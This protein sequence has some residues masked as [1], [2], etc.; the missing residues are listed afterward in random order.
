MDAQLKGPTVFMRALN[1]GL[2]GGEEL[3]GRHGVTRCVTRGVT[4]HVTR[5][6]WIPQHE[7]SPV[8]GQR[9]INENMHI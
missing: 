1:N 4:G 5:V 9:Q 3:A 8:S 2:V 6:A 7:L